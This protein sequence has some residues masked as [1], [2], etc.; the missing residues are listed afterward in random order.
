MAQHLRHQTTIYQVG[1]PM[2]NGY[3]ERFNRLC[4]EIVLDEYI[5]EDLHQIK[6]L[7]VT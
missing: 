4:R 5:F 1:R 2:K 3:I 6:E 7:T